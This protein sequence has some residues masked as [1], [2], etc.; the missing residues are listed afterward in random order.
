VLT[1]LPPTV[2]GAA[3]V[4]AADDSPDPLEPPELHAVSVSKATA[5]ARMGRRTGRVG[6]VRL[7]LM[8]SG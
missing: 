7:R 3:L 1:T 6:G 2:T 5:A 8:A 4:G